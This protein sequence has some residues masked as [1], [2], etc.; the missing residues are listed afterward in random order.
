MRVDNHDEAVL[1]SLAPRAVASWLRMRGFQSR[2]A[3]G[4]YGALFGRQDEDGEHEVLLPTS[5]D[6]RDF[7]RRMAELLSDLV[8]IERR[9]AHD[10]LNDLTLAPFDVI[11]LR[12][13]GADS[14]GSVRL[15]AGVDLHEEV[16][17]IIVA[18][19][20]AAASPLPRKSWRGAPPG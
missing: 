18:A 5:P 20:N 3:Y 2:G 15:S 12:S 8:Q 4:E 7:S 10:V 14:Y 11:K 19:A 9:P 13:P 6:V 17:N 1:A 16:T